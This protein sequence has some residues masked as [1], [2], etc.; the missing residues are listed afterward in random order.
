[1]FD[2]D[3]DDGTDD[4]SVHDADKLSGWKHPLQTLSSIPGVQLIV[5]TV[6]SIQDLDDPFIDLWLK[7][8]GHLISHLSVEL[9]VSEDRLDLLEFSEAAAPCRSIH[10]AISDSTGQV[11]DL[12]DLGPMAGSLHYLTCDA[13]TAE[14]RGI[15]RNATAFQ[16]M[17]QLTALELDR[18]EFAGV[19]PWGPLA[20]L[21]SLQK[22]R[23][24]VSAGGDPSPLSALTK[25]SDLV[26]ES[27]EPS[28]AIVPAPFSF[29]SLQP[30]STLQQLEVFHL[31][32]F[33]CDA[34]SLQGLAGLS[35]LLRLKI[36][37]DGGIGGASLKLRSLE[38]ISLGV[39]EVTVGSA[40][41][42]VS[43]AG[44]EGCTRIEK[45][46]VCACG[47]SSLQSLRGLSSMKELVVSWCPVTSLEGL[48]RMSLQ[49]LSLTYCSSLTQLSGVEHLPA[50][51][52]LRVVGCGVTS[53]QPLSLL[54]EGLQKLEVF[55][56]RSVQEEVL[57]LPHVQPTAGVRVSNSRV[58]EVV[59]AGGVRRAV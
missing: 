21:A 51:K 47:V 7:Q 39:Q 27:I 53:L 32:G 18:E 42:L 30:L 35:N 38:G 14:E 55:D 52:S 29:S 50:L 44:I 4:E 58:K 16:S 57:E 37:A 59:L 22:L 40:P 17:S 11:V 1:M 9:D 48:N 3:D 43:L 6:G 15:L 25:L 33:A 19:G 13:Y 45:L 41:D 24:R 46:S 54:G 36:V 8:H 31:E 28:Y 10:L 26:L 34:T 2:D 23:L 5:E 12:A 49:S 56:C 20:E